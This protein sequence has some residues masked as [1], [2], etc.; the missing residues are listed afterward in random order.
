MNDDTSAM[1]DWVVGI[2]IADLWTNPSYRPSVYYQKQEGS[3]TA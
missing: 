3:E 2:N 1:T